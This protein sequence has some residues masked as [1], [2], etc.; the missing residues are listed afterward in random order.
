MTE[1]P[2][3]TRSNTSPRMY[4][5]RLLVASMRRLSSASVIGTPA[6]RKV[7]IC[8]EKCMMSTSGTFSLVSSTWRPL[9]SVMRVTRRPWTASSLRAAFAEGASIWPLMTSPS[10]VW[11][12]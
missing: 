7:A 6:R 4:L 9:R 2:A 1:R 5:K 11:A 8:R 12:S 3:V 10:S